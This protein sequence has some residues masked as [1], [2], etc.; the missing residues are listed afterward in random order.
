MAKAIS[1]IVALLALS[2][3]ASA[4]K[5]CPILEPCT[6]GFYGPEAPPVC[7]TFTDENGE[8]QEQC[9]AIGSAAFGVVLDKDDRSV[10]EDTEI[11]E[12]DFSGHCDCTLTLW[13][14]PSFDGEFIKYRFEAS[15]PHFYINEIWSQDAE[16]FSV[17]CKF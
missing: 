11:A 17:T 13:N 8:Q 4:R 9:F 14:S 3:I 2:Y 12:I 1:L 15:R 6:L 10:D 5:A 16:S 7:Q